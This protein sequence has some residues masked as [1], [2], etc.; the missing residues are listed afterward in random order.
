MQNSKIIITNKIIFG[1]GLIIISGITFACWQYHQNSD[2]AKNIE[3]Q[4]LGEHNYYNPEINE[5]I[6]A[7]YCFSH[8]NDYWCR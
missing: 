8:A 4:K 6:D 2:F 1:I 5:C 7:S 3:C